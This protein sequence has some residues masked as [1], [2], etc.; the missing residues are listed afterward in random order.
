MR[1]VLV[2][3]GGA[4]NPAMVAALERHLAPARLVPISETGLPGDGK[5][6]LLIAL[7]LQSRIRGV[8]FFRTAFALPFAFSVATASVTSETV[9][10]TF[11]L[12]LVG[13]QLDI[14]PYRN[15]VPRSEGRLFWYHPVRCRQRCASTVRTVV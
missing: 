9:N 1:E 5:E 6:A 8:R 7:L 2:S 15:L 14:C 12:K 10:S 4:R 3:G 13:Q 11:L